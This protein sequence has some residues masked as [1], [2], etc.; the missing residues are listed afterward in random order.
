MKNLIYSHHEMVVM[1]DEAREQGRAESA[2]RIK[3][4]ERELEREKMTPEARAMAMLHRT[5]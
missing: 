2:E 3:E 5:K 4:L 1:C